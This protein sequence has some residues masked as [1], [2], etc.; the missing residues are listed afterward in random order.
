MHLWSVAGR[1]CARTPTRGWSV[2]DKS[3]LILAP[4]ATEAEEIAT[5]RVGHDGYEWLEHPR[6]IEVYPVRA[7][8]YT[9]HLT[10]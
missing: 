6:V 9:S 5:Q 8:D 7:G 2:V 3:L 1:L 4:T 10:P